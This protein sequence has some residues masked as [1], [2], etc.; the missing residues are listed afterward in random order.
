MTAA[1]Q[2]VPAVP[3]VPA[4]PEVQAPAIP[5]VPGQG[6][7]VP[8]SGDTLATV[9]PPTGNVQPIVL[10]GQVPGV[11][12][13][14]REEPKAAG[15]AG[16]ASPDMQAVL[17]LLQETLAKQKGSPAPTEALSAPVPGGEDLNKLDIAS[18]EDPAI[19]SMAYA[20]KV[21]G[22]D[23]D[24]NRALGHAISHGDP[25]LIDSHYLREKGGQNADALI[26]IAKGIVQAVEQQSNATVDRIMQAVG[27]EQAWKASVA[28]FNTAAP[29][30]LRTTVAQML[31][32]GKED[33][34]QA[35]AKIVAEFGKNSGMI[36]RTG[37]SPILNTA[38]AP[39]SGQALSKAEFQYALQKL[40]RNAPNYLESREEL[41]NRRRVGKQIGL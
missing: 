32:S 2:D 12:P 11:P 39:Q 40:D 29:K 13:Q 3:A 15:E 19:R 8:P 4:V 35:G 24:M 17:A 21:A 22:P 36:P 31:N 20:L 26:E 6:F 18:I 9:A 5:N 16:T 14:R 1:A 34:I 33:L 30:E 7:S 37:A 10:P 23:I 38:G 25:S 27:G 41:F 28:V